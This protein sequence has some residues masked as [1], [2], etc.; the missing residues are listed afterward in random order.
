MPLSIRSNAGP[1]CSVICFVPLDRGLDL[2]FD[3]DDPAARAA[4]AAAAAV[5]F[6]AERDDDCF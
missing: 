4:A 2:G 5:D 6:E 1:D 3:A